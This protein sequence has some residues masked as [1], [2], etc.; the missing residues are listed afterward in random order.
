MTPAPRYSADQKPRTYV[1]ENVKGD[2]NCAFCRG[3][4]TKGKANA[5]GLY[6]PCRCISKQAMEAKQAE[7]DRYNQIM[8]T[9]HEGRPRERGMGKK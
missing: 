3:A 4:G 6:K 9:L 7:V 5:L 8:R 1:A 2:P